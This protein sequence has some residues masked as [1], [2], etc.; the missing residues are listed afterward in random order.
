MTVT[1]SLMRP[2]EGATGLYI[3]FGAEDRPVLKNGGT[4]EAKLFD[5]PHQKAIVYVCDEVDREKGYM[6]EPGLVTRSSPEGYENRTLYEVWM[7]KK[8]ALK[9]L[10]GGD[11][12]CR[13]MYDRL[14]M[15][16]WEEGMNP[17][18]L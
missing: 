6:G 13:C 14:H 12:G 3:S 8:V 4:L 16:Y 15:T 1:N 7:D 11:A 17:R 9:L 5:K 2:T 10:T 18:S